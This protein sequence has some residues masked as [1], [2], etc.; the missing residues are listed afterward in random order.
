MSLH[1]RPVPAPKTLKDAPSS[2]VGSH[3][4]VLPEPTPAPPPRDD[5]SHEGDANAQRDR[6][7]ETRVEPA[8]GGETSR[9]WYHRERWLAVMLAAF[10]PLAA[11]AL[12]PSAAQY[13]LLGLTG[14]VLIVGAAMLIRQDVFRAQPGS[15]PGRK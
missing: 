3:S 10:V 8:V 1:S 13:A 12:A 14:L 9:P 5:R 15:E 7:P 11:A 4:A 2:P 6:P